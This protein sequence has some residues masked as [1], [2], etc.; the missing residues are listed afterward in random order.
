MARKIFFKLVKCDDCNQ[1]YVAISDRKIQKY[2]CSGY[3]RQVPNTCTIRH[4]IEE[5]ELLY[6]IQIF[7]NRNN[8]KMEY[9]NDFIKSI[10]DKIVVSRKNDSIAINYKNGENGIYSLKQIHI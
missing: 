6:L 9:T 1:N 2:L 5:K 3:S 10:V 7:C 8:I 4:T